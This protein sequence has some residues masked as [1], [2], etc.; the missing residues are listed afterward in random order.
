MCFI[1]ILWQETFEV[2]SGNGESFTVILMN[3]KYVPI[4]FV[5]LFSLTKAIKNGW[6]LK[7]GGADLLLSS[8]RK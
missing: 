8:N 7:S 5:N 4:L 1:A 6:Q 3:C 2:V